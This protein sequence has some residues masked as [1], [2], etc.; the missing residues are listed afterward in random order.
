MLAGH[1]RLRWRVT[2][3]TVPMGQPGPIGAPVANRRTP[4][5]RNWWPYALAAGILVTALA[6]VAYVASGPYRTLKAIQTAIESSDSQSLNEYV[7]FPTLR[8]NLK[9]QLNARTGNQ[10]QNALGT[11]LL[12][13]VAGGV[14]NSVVDASVELL[15][16]PGGLNKLVLGASV[17]A[18]Q[19]QG[20]T[21]GTLTQRFENGQ[22][23]FDS[24]S[25]FTFSV[26]APS[27]RQL[28]LVLTRIGLAWQLTN[29]VLPV[30]P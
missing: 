12:A 11:G 21:Q 26:P 1:L 2:H 14:A 8:Q 18:G 6:G 10:V 19:F 9:Q 20:D 4:K 24:L 17:V 25:Q 29:I 15:V 22:G 30:Q 27:N 13:Q 16:A 5:R 7:D 28:V 3:D 23:S